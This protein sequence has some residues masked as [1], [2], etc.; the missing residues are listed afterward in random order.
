M[1]DVC[2][3][4][5]KHRHATQAAAAL[6]RS[7]M[8]R[9]VETTV[10]TYRCRYCQDWHVGRLVRQTITFRR[11]QHGRKKRSWRDELNEHLA[12]DN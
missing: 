6:H 2:V 1:V 12:R 3:V 4:T 8:Q 7:W 10:N 11:K 9:A 5:G